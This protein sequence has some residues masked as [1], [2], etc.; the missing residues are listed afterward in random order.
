[1][2]NVFFLVLIAS[3]NS[4]AESSSTYAPTYIPVVQNQK[5][6]KLCSHYDRT[7]ITKQDINAN[8]KLSDSCRIKLTLQPDADHVYDVDGYKNDPSLTVKKGTILQVPKV[9]WFSNAGSNT[10]GTI[11]VNECFENDNFN[12]FL[13]ETVADISSAVS[14]YYRI[15]SVLSGLDQ[16]GKS[17][18][19]VI[20]CG[21][22]MDR[23]STW[24]LA[25]RF[26]QSQNAKE[27]KNLYKSTFENY[28]EDLSKKPFK[29][30]PSNMSDMP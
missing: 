25:G 18:L 22:E 28:F 30:M 14:G 20:N 19:V 6:E 16:T 9:W 23:V 7:F 12:S 11:G 17:V 2:K 3:L 5:D 8:L 10:T 26:K 24:N 15:T 4:F 1:M 21:Q 29:I 27:I 13:H